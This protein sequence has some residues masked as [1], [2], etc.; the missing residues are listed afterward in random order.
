MEVYCPEC[1]TTYTTPDKTSSRPIIKDI[2]KTC[3][4]TLSI[5]F[6]AGQVTTISKR[7]SPLSKE[8]ETLSVESKREKEI[9]PMKSPLQIG[10]VV[11]LFLV[12]LAMAILS[13][14]GSFSQTLGRFLFGIMI[15][16]TFGIYVLKPSRKCPLCGSFNGLRVTGRGFGGKVQLTCSICN[17]TIIRGD[18]IKTL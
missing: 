1:K 7:Q 6:N 18:N 15:V 11:L 16:V 9:N 17:L 3:G 13:P 2:C 10:G 4:T 14:D 5:D 8:T 12:S